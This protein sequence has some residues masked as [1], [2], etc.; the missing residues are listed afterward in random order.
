M[1]K[2]TVRDQLVRG[3]RRRSP[4]Q[5]SWWMLA[6][7]A[8]IVLLVVVAVQDGGSTSTDSADSAGSLSGAEADAV[9]SAETL[10]DSAGT[11][12]TVQSAAEEERPAPPADEPAEETANPAESNTSKE[13]TL[14]AQ[15]LRETVDRL[16]TTPPGSDTPYD[17]DLFGQSWYDYD[18]NGCDTRN[19]VL[20]R[21]LVNVDFKPGTNDC[22]VVSGTLEDWYS[23]ETVAFTSGKDTS[24]LVQVDHIVPLSWAWKHGADAWDDDTRL[25]FANDP[26]NL[27]ATTEAENQAK[28]DSGP[29]EWLPTDLR[30]T[31]RYV[32]RFTVVLDSYSLSIGLRDRA[33]M[34]GLL[35][36][37]GQS[38]EFGSFAPAT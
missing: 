10:S 13:Q 17:R 2:G 4:H 27:N 28:S 9:Q 8:L 5:A 15:E 30:G 25:R 36:E 26:A 16:Q 24:R 31:C 38:E 32:E 6:G 37:C 22:K 18:R 29:S 33:A 3:K 11:S 34:R 20:G 21:D 14:R 1:S 19:D 7:L 23:G 12:A 35:I